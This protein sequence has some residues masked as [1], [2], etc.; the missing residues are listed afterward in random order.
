MSKSEKNVSSF[1][2]AIGRSLTKRDIGDIFKDNYLTYATYILLERAIPDIRDGM[3]P[4]NRR[5]LYLMNESNYTSG[6]SYKKSARVVGEVMG[7]LHP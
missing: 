5:I 2:Q 6:N 4:I 7:K 1:Q 3:K